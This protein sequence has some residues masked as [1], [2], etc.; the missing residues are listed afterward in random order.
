MEEI[1]KDTG[2]AA[3]YGTNSLTD[4]LARVA[5]HGSYF[6]TLTYTS[7]NPATDGRFGK[8]QVKLGPTRLPTR[9]PPRLL[10]GRREERP[11]SPAGS[12]TGC[13]AALSD[14]CVL[15][16]QNRPRFLSRCG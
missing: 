9:L 6:Y 8:I 5:D 1:A 14:S 10:C 3:F 16:C 2:G 12:Q 4:A 11:S 13:R 7:T 15:A